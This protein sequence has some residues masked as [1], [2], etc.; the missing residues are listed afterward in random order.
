[1]Y[2]D[3][4]CRRFISIP[5]HGIAM[6][7]ATVAIYHGLLSTIAHIHTRECELQLCQ[8]ILMVI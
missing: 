1:M 4:L 2:A 8:G 7:A 3:E 5:I 6:V